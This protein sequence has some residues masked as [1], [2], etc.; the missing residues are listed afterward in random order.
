MN[1]RSDIALSF[2]ISSCLLP[3]NKVCA[4]YSLR[5]SKLTDIYICSWRNGWTFVSRNSESC[6][7]VRSESCISRYKYHSTHMFHPSALCM[8][9][10]GS[11]S[12]LAGEEPPERTMVPVPSYPSNDVADRSLAH[13]SQRN[14]LISWCIHVWAYT[15]FRFLYVY[16]FVSCS[17]HVSW[18]YSYQYLLCLRKNMFITH[19]VGEDEQTHAWNKNYHAKFGKQHSLGLPY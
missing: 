9:F 18:S 16:G 6:T 4:A 2:Y 17:W 10:D 14:L 12:F 3:A 1:P 15:N 19:F 7:T 8:K 13:I 5:D 11:F